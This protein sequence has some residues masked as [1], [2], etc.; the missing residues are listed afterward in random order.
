MSPAWIALCA[1]LLASSCAAPLPTDPMILGRAL[2]RPGVE[3]EP[4]ASLYKRGFTAAIVELDMANG[5]LVSGQNGE[6]AFESQDFLPLSRAIR[7]DGASGSF[8]L[9]LLLEGNGPATYA[10]L[11]RLLHDSRQLLTRYEG[12]RHV[13]GPLSIVLAGSVPIDTLAA[14]RTRYA[15]ASGGREALENSPY[16]ADLLPLIRLTYPSVTSWDGEDE[17]PRSEQLALQALTARAHAQGR[18]VAVRGAPREAWDTLLVVGVDIL[19]VGPADE[20]EATNLARFLGRR[21]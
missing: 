12:G 14:E 16:S 7:E 13:K 9:V 18:M 5:T 8:M 1:T 6:R 3:V 21:R 20:R 11:N 10:S 4:L 2:V 19:E 15:F 17:I